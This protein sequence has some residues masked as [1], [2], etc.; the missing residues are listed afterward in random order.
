ML[1]DEKLAVYEDRDDLKLPRLF[2]R[3]SLR[4]KNTFELFSPKKS[5]RS[6]LIQSGGNQAPE[7]A[8][9]GHDDDQQYSVGSFFVALFIRCTLYADNCY[10]FGRAFALPDFPRKSRSRHHGYESSIC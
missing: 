9:H 3:S 1:E 5:G 4:F 7:C 6:W 10:F 2:S 8:M